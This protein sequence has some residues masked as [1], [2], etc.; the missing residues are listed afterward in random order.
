MSEN[1]PLI[2]FNCACGK[3]VQTPAS[4]CGQKLHCPYPGCE[5]IIEAPPA[6]DA[7]PASPE[8]GSPDAAASGAPAAGPRKPRMPPPK[9]LKGGKG[10]DLP[11]PVKKPRPPAAAG[12][13]ATPAKDG[14]KPAETPASEPTSTAEPVAPPKKKN[15]LFFAACSGITLIVA[16]FILTKDKN[17]PPTPAPAPAPAVAPAK[18]A[19]VAAPAQPRQDPAPPVEGGGR[20]PRQQVDADAMSARLAEK[21]AEQKKA[22]AGAR[23]NLV[24]AAENGAS[25]EWL[26]LAED[27]LQHDSEENRAEARKWLEKAAARRTSR[28]FLL[29]GGLEEAHG[30]REKAVDY[31]VQGAASIA[32]GKSESRDAKLAGF[33]DRLDRLEAADEAAKIRARIAGEPKPEAKPAPAVPAAEAKP[34]P[35]PAPKAAPAAEAK[36]APVEEVPGIPEPPAP[37][38]PAP[39]EEV[40]GIPEPPAAPAV[41]APAE[42]VPGIPEPPAPNGL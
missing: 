7:V 4:L 21:L 23:K 41:P 42:E 27:L 26:A 25:E 3:P 14:D 13:T 35:A 29:L 32:S 22:A 30:S 10:K 38:V 18:P 12:T 15:K 34:A 31:Y 40:P 9:G 11:S 33:A 37:A 17:K 16:V 36:P 6:A 1:E 19:A 39:A 20:K 5:A 2:N 28:A 24:T 8:A